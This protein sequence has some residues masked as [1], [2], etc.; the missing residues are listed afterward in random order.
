[1]HSGHF[2]S[3]KHLST[4][5]DEQNANAQ[6]FACNIHNKG[7]QYKHSLYI[8]EKYGSG[9]AQSLHAKSMIINKMTVSDYLEIVEK[10][11]LKLKELTSV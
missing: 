9:T 2:I 4:R 3:R 5:F 1:M 11:T 7:E 10:F 6:C 8:D